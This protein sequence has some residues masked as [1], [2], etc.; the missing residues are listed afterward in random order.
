MGSCGRAYS[1]GECQ[2]GF[3]P[4]TERKSRRIHQ[5]HFHS[6]PVL[7]VHAAYYLSGKLS[8]GP[9]CLEMFITISVDMLGAPGHVITT[10]PLEQFG[11]G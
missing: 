8:I 9:R 3:N 10:C 7:Q 6:T 4:N 5:P 2:S 11:C 1:E